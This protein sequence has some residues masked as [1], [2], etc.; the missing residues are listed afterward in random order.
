MHIKLFYMYIYI[1][2]Y[3]YIERERERE[4]EKD[5]SPWWLNIKLIKKLQITDKESMKLAEKVPRFL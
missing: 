4:R 1:Y 2:I 5:V 3:I